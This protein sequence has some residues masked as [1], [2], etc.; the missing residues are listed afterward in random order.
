MLEIRK[1]LVPVDLSARSGPAV[2]H[3]VNIAQH[4]NAE[5]IVLHAIQGHP[6]NPVLASGYPG[7]LTPDP[8]D[9]EER[10]DELLAEFLKEAV[11][12]CEA[13]H[14][15]IKAEPVA[16][17]KRIVG[18]RHIDLIVM[19][20]S[21]HG[22]FRNFVLGTVTTKVLDEVACPV[23]TGAHVE[24]IDAM[25]LHPYKKVGCAIDLGD[26]SA[27]VLEKAK[28][29]AAAYEAELTTVIHALSALSEMP[30]STGEGSS[31]S[32]GLQ[33]RAKLETQKLIDAAKVSAEPIVEFGSPEELIPRTIKDRGI[34]VLVMGRHHGEGNLSDLLTQAYGVIR[35]SPC[36]VLS[37]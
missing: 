35:Q 22:L 25:A 13:E 37:I 8:P 10:L 1:I 6:Y 27:E 9:Q 24:D 7:G 33:E 31:P 18:E 29:F 16:L 4:F 3:G 19:P 5:V 36:P 21:G 17:I 23:L 26:G 15:V 28:A 32:D 20:T 2:K 34:D 30:R 14:V 12:G 11:P